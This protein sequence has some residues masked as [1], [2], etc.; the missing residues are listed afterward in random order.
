MMHDICDSPVSL[1]SQSQLDDWNG[2]VHGVLSH[3]TKP[4]IHLA[5]LLEANPDFAMGHAARGLFM[6]MTG[7]KEMLTLAVES[8]KTRPVQY[9]TAPP[10]FGQDTD[11]VLETLKSPKPSQ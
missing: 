2:V 7:R 5:A 11:A 3:G 8:A 9:R 1:S 6:V 4:G 10:R